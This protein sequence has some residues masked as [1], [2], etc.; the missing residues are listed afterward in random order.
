MKGVP[1][2]KPPRSAHAWKGRERKV[3][4]G[5]PR[6]MEGR[7]VASA[8]KKRGGSGSCVGV[9]VRGIGR[10]S[11]CWSEREKS[12]SGREKGRR[13][14]KLLALTREREENPR[15]GEREGRRRWKRGRGRD[16]HIPWGQ[17]DGAM[18]RHGT[19]VFLQRVRLISGRSTA[20]PAAPRWRG[21]ER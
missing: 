9:R 10:G 20:Q 8:V 3:V 11:L 6:A 5:E 1:V 17:W 2:T 7:K 19:L 4:G 21:N 14:A 15:W 18:W 12:R 13:S 16:L